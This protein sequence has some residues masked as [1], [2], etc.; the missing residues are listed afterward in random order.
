MNSRLATLQEN[1]ALLAK[2]I[3]ERLITM[4]YAKVVLVFVTGFE[5]N[6]TLLSIDVLRQYS[7]L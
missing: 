2:I 5:N 7:K 3:W 1:T 4:T 6:S